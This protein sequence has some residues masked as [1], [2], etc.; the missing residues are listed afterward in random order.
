MAVASQSNAPAYLVAWS[1]G[2]SRP[3]SL[4]GTP[5]GTTGATLLVP[6]ASDGTIGLGTTLGAARITA[7]VVGYVLGD[8]VVP[9]PSGQASQTEQAA[10][11]G[12]RP[13]KPR[14]V[15]AKSARRAVTT[16]WKAPV[17]AGSHPITEYRV[18]ALTSAKRGA[19]VAGS[20]TTSAET[21]KCTIKGLKKGKKY[22]MSVSVANPVGSTW[23]ARRAVRVR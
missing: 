1:A 6:I 7:Q 17:S 9:A 20:C 4:L 16:R 8:P 2:G 13:T 22:W 12:Q 21:R 10:Q 11:A 3:G 15:K 19:K 18:E 5:I 23:A 14:A